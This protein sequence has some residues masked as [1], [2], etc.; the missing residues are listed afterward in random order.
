MKELIEL[1]NREQRRKFPTIPD[2]ARPKPKYSDRTSNGLTKCIIDYLRLC[3]CQAE[4]IS[5]TGRYID[6]SKVVVDVLGHARRIGTGKWIPTSG[7]KGSADIS[8][9]IAGRSIKIEVKVGKDKQS[10]NQVEYQKQIE[11][12]GGVY[13]IVGSWKRFIE[14]YEQLMANTNKRLA[15]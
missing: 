12:A 4:R 3:G 13:I 6:K 10:K 9:T 2:H 8:A 11:Q 5:T 1:S 7:Q 15:T 14:W